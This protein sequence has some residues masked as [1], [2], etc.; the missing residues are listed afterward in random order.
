[1]WLSGASLHRTFGLHFTWSK[2]TVACMSLICSHHPVSGCPNKNYYQCAKKPHNSEAYAEGHHP[3]C[4]KTRTFQFTLSIRI[5]CTQLSHPLLNW[6]LP[7]K[8]QM[9]L[10]MVC[11]TEPSQHHVTGVGFGRRAGHTTARDSLGLSCCSS[12]ARCRSVLKTT[13]TVCW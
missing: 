13:G 12:L 7:D 11:P 5:V 3:S 6:G 9:H 8:T 2:M 1:M 10:Q 4:K